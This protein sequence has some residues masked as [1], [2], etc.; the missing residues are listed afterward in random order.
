MCRKQNDIN[1][2]T[3]SH[4]LIPQ[5]QI[6]AWVSSIFGKFSVHFQ[7]NRVIPIR[8]WYIKTNG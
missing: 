5:V 3:W 2:V 4:S 6:M 8:Q 1:Y 7:G